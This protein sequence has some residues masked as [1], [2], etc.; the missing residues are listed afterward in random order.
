MISTGDLGLYSYLQKKKEDEKHGNPD[1]FL[2]NFSHTYSRFNH[3]QVYNSKYNPIPLSNYEDINSSDN[4]LENNKKRSKHIFSGNKIY[5]SMEIKHLPPEIND[6]NEY[7]KVYAGRIKEY[8]GPQQQ[9]TLSNYKYNNSGY[10]KT[11]KPSFIN[12]DGKGFD[13]SECRKV[14]LNLHNDI[15]LNSNYNGIL[16][17]DNTEHTNLKTYL[18]YNKA[19]EKISILNQHTNDVEYN[20]KNMPPVTDMNES[21]KKYGK[22]NITDTENLKK[23]LRILKSTY[24]DKKKYIVSP[25]LQQTTENITQSNVKKIETIKSAGIQKNKIITDLY[26]DKNIKSHMP[27]RNDSAYNIATNNDVKGKNDINNNKNK[28]LQIYGNDDIYARHRIKTYPF[29]KAPSNVSDA[30]LN[31]MPVNQQVD[32]VLKKVHEDVNTEKATT[33]FGEFE[34]HLQI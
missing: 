5:N 23:N 32:F 3:T 34:T 33:N 25:N 20:R 6:N 24:N 29:N 7:H 18:N 30:E 2:P 12:Y 14:L 22:Y 11:T 27:P 9:N 17:T 28:N 16:N 13:V 19:P 15:R 31:N 26:S 1:K 10:E 21:N 4:Y 8:I